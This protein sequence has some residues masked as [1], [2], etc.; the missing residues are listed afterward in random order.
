MKSVRERD[1][2]DYVWTYRE[3]FLERR[4]KEMQS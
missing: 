3:R 2:E 4:L 1:A